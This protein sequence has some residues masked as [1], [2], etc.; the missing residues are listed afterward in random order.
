LRSKK[1]LIIDDEQSL[2]ESLEMYLSE[3][4]Y[5]VECALSAREGIE[6]KGVFE[7]HVIILDIRLPDRNGLDILRELRDE[8][9]TTPVIMITAFHD[10]DTTIRTVKLGAFEYI[11]KPIDVDELR[12]A[13]ERALRFAS[14]P[15]GR[16]AIS[17]DPAVAYEERDIIGKSRTMKEVF[18]SVG[19]L[20]ENLVTVLIEGETGT[21]KELVARAIHSHGPF[22][23]EP[24]IAVNCSN[25]VGTLLES[26]LFGHEKGAFT[27]AT[28]TKRGK[29]ELAGRGT[30]LLDEIGEIPLDLQAKLLRVLQEKEFERV[31]GEKTIRSHA[32]VLASTNRD[33]WRL[34]RDGGFRSDLFYRLSVATIKVPALR[35]RRSDIPLLTAYLLKK[36]SNELKVAS[37]RIEKRAG[38]RLMAYDWPGNV[39]ELENVLTRAALDTQGE[40]IL[41]ETFG[42]LIG[43][44]FALGPEGAPAALQGPSLQDVERE[45]ILKVLNDTHWHFGKACELLGLSRPTLRSKLKAYGIAPAAP[46]SRKA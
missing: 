15:D 6:K 39:R 28:S 17:P 22:R 9:D 37:R 14:A 20:S 24:F 13:V 3:L 26:D 36:I 2:L 35:E 32:R 10:M 30:I 44:G 41:D 16:D 11:P 33:L 5:K 46:A 38:E 42:P 43:K 23:D 25:I 40:L 7:P 19:R 27:G 34:V 45:Y 18:K 8:S 1:I 31:G 29:F 4:G 21:G 12:G